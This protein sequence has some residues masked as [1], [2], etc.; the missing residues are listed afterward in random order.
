MYA[1]SAL[2]GAQPQGERRVMDCI[3]CHNRAAHTFVTAEEAINSAMAIGA[4]S[5]SLPFV[6]KEGL[7]LLNESYPSQAEANIEIPQKLEA[8]YRTQNPDVLA[9]KAAL[10]KQAG[11]ELALLYDENVFPFMK[12]TWGTHPN[13]I[14]HQE[15]PGCFRCH[16]GDHVAKDGDQHHAGL[17]RLPQPAGRGR[18]QAQS[19]RR[20]R[21]S[22]R[23]ESVESPALANQ[24][25]QSLGS[26]PHRLAN[27]RISCAHTS[28]IGC[29][30]RLTRYTISAKLKPY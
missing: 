24:I 29:L 26:N 3:D 25:A 27:D 1:A 17:L 12:V 16:D 18:S 8:F 14:G 2:H 11:Q 13:H 9:Q 22:I 10:V 7:V 6:H 23:A 19:S 28:R 5:P 30:I 21:H 4:I 15:Y 20:P